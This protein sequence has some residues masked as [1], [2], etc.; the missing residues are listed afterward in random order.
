[1]SNKDIFK[2]LYSKYLNKEK[3]YNK[4]LEDI[5][6]NK[7]GIDKH[8]KW[9]FI[10][11]C[12]IVVICG[13]MAFRNNNNSL[14]LLESEDKQYI[15]DNVI[16]NINNVI[17]EKGLAKIDGEVISNY[18]YIPYYEVLS[19]LKVPEDFDDK[20][21]NNVISIKNNQNYYDTS[22]YSKD[23]YL[24]QYQKILKNSSNNRSIT[25][26][27]SEKN[28]PLRDY[29]FEDVKLSK[30]NDFDLIIYKYENSY[31][32]KFKYKNLNIDIET[33]D[34]TEEEFISLLLSIIK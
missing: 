14:P 15:Y 23:Y 34:I 10:P 21:Y 5:E 22:I 19:N 17:E 8:L 24:V 18:Y 7:K 9:A 26:S 31:M 29:Y 16:L 4:I 13:V 33:S 12:L 28:E 11:I 2:E 3:N 6:R 27:Y 1:M 30:I 25:I 32:T 20:E